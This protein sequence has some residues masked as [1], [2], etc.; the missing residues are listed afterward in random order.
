MS[1]VPSFY[2]TPE[3]VADLV[4]VCAGLY[5]TPFFPN[6]EAPGEDGGM[7]CVH[8][9]NYVHRT[10]GAL[11]PVQIPRQVMDAGQ[12][13]PHSKLIEAFETWPELKA[14]FVC[15]WQQ[16]Q[17]GG[18]IIAPAELVPGDVLCFRAGLAPHHGALLLPDGWIFHT[19]AGVGAHRYQLRAAVRGWRILG[20]LAA[21]YRPLPLAAD[22]AP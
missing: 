12:H 5:G 14:R 18:P 19:L 21:V 3:R 4:R 13:S 1:A 6:S 7:D 17:E 16:T 20:E 2:A 11:G 9:L 10:C 15:V 8:L 22:A